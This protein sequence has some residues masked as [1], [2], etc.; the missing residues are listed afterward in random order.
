MR[1]TT[2][3]EKEVRIPEDSI[4]R[5]RLE[6]IKLR[7]FG[8]TDKRT[9]DERE[10]QVLDWW[11]RITST[12]YGDQYVGR[13]FKSECDAKLSSRSDNRFRMWAEALLGRDIP[14]GMAVDTDDLVGM[15]AE[16][17]IGYQPDR[18]DKNKTW[19]Y[20]SDV[21]PLDGSHHQYDPPF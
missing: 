6:E 20:V 5:A 16:I 17:V 12:T 15:E 11:W 13:R 1:F 7:T 9:G 21:A 14:V 2:E 8:W 19:P 10:A 3:E 4:H 18:R